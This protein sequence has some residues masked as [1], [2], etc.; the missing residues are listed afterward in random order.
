MVGFIAS[1]VLMMYLAERRRSYVMQILVYSALGA[2]GILFAFYAFRPAA[3]SYVF[4]GGGGR[5]W[6]SLDGAKGMFTRLENAPFVVTSGVALMVWALVRRSRYF[7]NTV[8]L[9]MTLVLLPLMTTQTVSAPWLWALPFLF[10]FVGGVFADVLETRQRRMFL[11][12]TGM[13]LVA[14]AVS[15]V[16]ALPGIAQ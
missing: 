7:G 8:P 14:Q 10:T 15:C 16:A 11:A 3:F 2:L 4:T 12:L 6:F 5:F 9:V 13:A 1:L